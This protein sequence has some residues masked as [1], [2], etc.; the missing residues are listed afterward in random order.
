MTTDHSHDSLLADIVQELD[1]NAPPAAPRDLIST[2]SSLFVQRREKLRKER[3]AR[4]DAAIDAAFATARAIARK[5]DECGD[6][7]GRD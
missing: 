4:K 7:Q 2:V 6:A 1:P 3:R 5:K